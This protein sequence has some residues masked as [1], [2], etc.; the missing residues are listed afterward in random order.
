MNSTP[1][2]L[3]A[4]SGTPLLHF[5]YPRTVITRHAI[6]YTSTGQRNAII[7]SR[8]VI[9]NS[10]R[11]VGTCCDDV[12]PER[13]EEEEEREVEGWKSSARVRECDLWIKLG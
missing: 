2:Q 6:Y 7:R 10:T 5:N 4:P 12:N 8:W 1:Y 9:E 13:R 3:K 11:V